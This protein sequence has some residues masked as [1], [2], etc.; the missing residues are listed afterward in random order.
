M[1]FLIHWREYET[2]EQVSLVYVML[3][4]L[5]IWA[6]WVLGF[7]LLERVMKVTKSSAHGNLAVLCIGLFWVGIH[8]GW[9]VGIST[10]FSPYRD[11]PGSRFGV[12]RYFFIFWTLID[13]GLLWFGIDKLRS[14]QLGMEKSPKLFELTRGGK[15]YF[16]EPNQIHWLAA[17]NYYTKLCTTQGTF[18]MR[19]PLKSFYDVLPSTKFKKIH[20][21]TI[22]N[23]DYVAELS[24]NNAQGLD[25][26]LRDGTRKRVS[27]TFTKEILDFF[28]DRTF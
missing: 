4:Q 7:K 17:E 16:C 12:F 8:Y 6:P 26:V 19:K 2:R 13:L 18:L 10:Y 15:K 22:I 9:F 11:L 23:V 14:G 27:R 1:G 28:K 20:R 25:M 21:S 5:V 24:R 3:W